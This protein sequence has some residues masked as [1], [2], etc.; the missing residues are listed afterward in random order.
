MQA[1]A[2]GK[3]QWLQNANMAARWR[4]DLLRIKRQVEHGPCV[5]CLFDDCVISDNQSMMMIVCCDYG[6]ESR[7]EAC[8]LSVVCCQVQVSA[9]SW[10]FVQ[11]SPTDCGVSWVW[12]GATVTLLHLQWVGWKSQTKERKKEKE[13]KKARERKREK[14]IRKKERERHR[15]K[16]KEREKKRGRER[17]KERKKE[18]MWIGRDL[19]GNGRGVILRTIVVNA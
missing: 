13:G 1:V 19:E 17:V 4:T 12:S 16:E 8:L 3:K 10:S 18:N 14:E 9:T 5:Y 7:R 6:F 15:Q 2:L 11:R